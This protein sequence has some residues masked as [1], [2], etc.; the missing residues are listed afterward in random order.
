MD[1]GLENR[2]ARIIK[3]ANG[4]T[5]MLAVDHGYFLGPDLGSRGTRRDDR[6]ARAATPTRSC[7]RAACCAPTSTRARHADRAAR[8]RRHERARDELSNETIIVDDRGCHPPQRRRHGA[9]GLRRRAARAPDAR[10]TSRKLVDEGERYGIPVIAVTAVGKD[11][12]R[13]ARYLALACRISAEIG[14]PHRQDVLLRRL[15]ATSSAHVPGAGRHGR[16]QEAARARGA[17]D[18][19]RTR[20]RRGARGVDMGRNIFQTDCPAG[21]DQGRPR[22]GARQRG[23]TTR[24]DARPCGRPGYRA[25]E[26]RR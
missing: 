15:R 17:R 1:W 13:D 14:R 3:P 26:A 23:A 9:V 12:V 2:L 18:D 24:S 21:H 16:R 5:V 20:C 25:E 8:L 4:R 19:V 6:A 22:R 7:S 11:M 10:S